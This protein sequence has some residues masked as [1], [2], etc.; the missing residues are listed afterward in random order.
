MTN[1]ADIMIDDD[2]N[3][4]DG[5]DPGDISFT[6]PPSPKTPKTQKKT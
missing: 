3:D 1:V 2:D 4:D 6:L 5:D